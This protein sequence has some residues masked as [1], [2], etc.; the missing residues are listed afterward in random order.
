[1]LDR[2]DSD[3]VGGPIA[4]EGSVE[5][6]RDLGLVAVLDRAEAGLV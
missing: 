6:R 1:V 2:W 3:R 5:Q 4:V